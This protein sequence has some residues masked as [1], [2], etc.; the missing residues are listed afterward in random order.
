MPSEIQHSAAHSAAPEACPVTCSWSAPT[1]ALGHL[2][3]LQVLPHS[4][5]LETC[6]AR[7]KWEW[8]DHQTLSA[9]GQGTQDS[10]AGVPGLVLEQRQ[11]GLLVCRAGS[12]LV[13]GQ[14]HTAFIFVACVTWMP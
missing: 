8:L 5:A 13:G 7:G 3:C 11:W 12:L 6:P 4:T 10:P 9:H 2:R 1:P 14:A